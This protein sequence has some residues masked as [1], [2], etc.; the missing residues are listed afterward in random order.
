MKT[1]ITKDSRGKIRI[2]KIWYEWDDSQRGYV[3]RRITS[4]LGGK[5]TVQPEIW[6][7]K[8]KVKRTV[9]EQCNLEFNSHVKKYLDK[10]YKEIDPSI[11]L[12][13]VSTLNDIIG[14]DKT[15]QEGI[16]KPM[17]AKQADKVANSVFN[18]QYLGSRKI[19][20]TRCLIYYK[21]GKV[22]TASRG[23][24]NYDLAISHIID[25]PKMIKFFEENPSVIL[26][27]EIYKHGMSLNTI[28]GMCRTQVNAYE[29]EVLE[30]YLYDI[31][32]TEMPFRE[33]LEV[34]NDIADQLELKEFDPYRK[35]EDN[36]LKIQVV[37]H[38]QM[39]GWLNIKSYH[40][41][42]VKEGWEGLVIRNVN[43]VYGPGKRS[44]AMLKIKEYMDSEYEIVGISEGL[45]DEDMCFIMKTT[46]GQEFKAKPMGDRALKQWYRD[47]IDSI[48]GK[49]GTL[50]YFEMSGK[51]GSDIPQQPIF[52]YIRELD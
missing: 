15:N 3:I 5:E 27:G 37:P 14:E 10:G 51:E 49:M 35:W 40:D 42:Y 21:D 19:N 16:I 24:I 22:R 36:S 47:N 43:D 41:K 50:K 11:D 33:R 44:N 46:S 32:N 23:A 20:G 9:T 38:I 17:L 1:L 6:I 30:F 13:D 25:H 31:V 18:K 4:Q 48:I 2:V 28:S 7:F 52:M 29:G 26:D 8:G 45:R 39:S 34:I 12:N